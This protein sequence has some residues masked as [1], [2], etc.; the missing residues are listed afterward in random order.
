[1]HSPYEIVSKFDLFQ[2]F[3]GYKI[4]LQKMN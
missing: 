3:K 2:T 1:M 4:F